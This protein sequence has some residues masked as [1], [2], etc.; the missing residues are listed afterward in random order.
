MKK[1]ALIVLLAVV[2][3]RALTDR[4]D[5]RHQTSQRHHPSVRQVIF[6]DDDATPPPPAPRIA[7]PRPPEPPPSR[8]PRS[9]RRPPVSPVETVLAANPKVA[10]AWFPKAD[11]EEEGLARSDAAGT[12]VLLGRLMATEDRAS[13]SL[14]KTLNHEVTDWLAADVP[15]TWNPPERLLDRMVLGTHIQTVTRSFG[16][17]PPE[18]VAPQP[19]SGAEILPGFE[20]QWTLYRAGQK[21]DFSETRRAEFL[22]S[23]H[24]DVASARMR[25]SG[26]VIAVVLA[27]LAATSLYVR[28]DEATKGYY[29]NRL[30]GLAAVGLGVAGVAAY[31]YWA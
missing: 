22:E 21:L 23:Y 8:G 29:T 16:A 30:R 17:K 4:D 11:W 3:S 19:E 18:G 10:P 26:S 15:V 1:L 12:R 27:L 13:A 20:D 14:R 7:A 25:R 5:R 31:R 28:A 2:A 24:R 6:G 9:K